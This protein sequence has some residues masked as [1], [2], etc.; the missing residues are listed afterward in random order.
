MGNDVQIITIENGK[1]E[2]TFALRVD[3]GYLYAAGGTGNNNYLKTEESK[4]VGD[5][6]VLSWNITIDAN[7]I[8][9]IVSADSTVARNTMRYNKTNGLFSCYASGQEDI[10]IYKFSL[11]VEA[12]NHEHVECP[13]C[14]LCT[15]EDC[16]GEESEKCKGHNQT[17]SGVLNDGDQIM[18]ATVRSSGNYFIASND[19]G[20]ASTKRYQ[21]V[22]SGV[23]DPSSLPSPVENQIWTVKVVSGGY[24]LTTVVGGEIMYATWS[25]GNSGN[26][27]EDS[28]E[29]KVFT[30]DYNAE[31]NTYNIHFAASDAERYFALNGT[32]GNNYFAFYKSGQKQDLTIIKIQENN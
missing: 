25:S 27:T 1:N 13:I 28:T 26:L 21:A 18:I 19:L 6:L 4:T 31:N 2:G 14:K 7:G 22:D 12:P 24:L 29:A 32:S 10:S 30:I 9:T 20:T 16:D 11:S 15:V 5:A 17:P 8:A 3:N 23:S